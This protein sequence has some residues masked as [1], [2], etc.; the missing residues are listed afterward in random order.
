MAEVRQDTKPAALR[1]PAPQFG[2]T[3]A[4]L[5]VDDPDPEKTRRVTLAAEQAL[6]LSP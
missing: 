4:R 3:C 6:S 1:V 2:A 5:S